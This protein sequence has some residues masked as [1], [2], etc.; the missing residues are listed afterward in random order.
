MLKDLSDNLNILMAKARLSSSELARQIGVPATTIKRI[1]T[2]EQ[3]NPT[4]ATLLPIAQYF[5]ISINQLIGNELFTSA[6]IVCPMLLH[7]I[8]ILSWQECIHHVLIDYEKCSTQILTERNLS[9]K[10]FAL[11]IEENDLEFFPKDSILIIEP[12]QKPETGDYVIIGNIKQNIASIRK[13]IIELD[14]IYLKPL[15]PGVTISVLTP[16]FKILGVIIQ[17][18]M[19]LK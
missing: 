3:S 9:E 17:Y 2:N 6:N 18:K 10:A 12:N 15:V 8:P 4:I 16:E 5:S 13:F 1:R 11:I 19:E 7:K 14:Q